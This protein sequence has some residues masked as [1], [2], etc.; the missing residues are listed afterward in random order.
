MFRCVI[1]V[2]TKNLFS[3]GSL[4]ARSSLV[5]SQAKDDVCIL[6]A[7]LSKFYTLH[8][9]VDESSV[10]YFLVVPISSLRCCLVCGEENLALHSWVKE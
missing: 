3:F 10:Y 5:G 6:Y 2:I 9:C 4:W 7:K 8:Q 1:L